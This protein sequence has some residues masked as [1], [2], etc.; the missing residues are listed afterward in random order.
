MT[1]TLYLIDGSGF[2]F[3]AYHA[4]PPLT[5]KDGTPVGAVYGFLNMILKLIEG[6]CADYLAVIFDAGRF[7]FRNEIYDKY[8][9]NRTET[10]E[11]LI[12]QFPLVREATAAMNL[13]AIELAGFEADDLIASYTRA[14]REKGI[15]VVIVSSD[16]DLM[17]LIGDGV[18]MYDAM[19]GRNIG[20]EQVKEKFG[21]TPDKVLDVLSLIG[22]SSDNVPGVPGIGPKTA[23]ELIEQFGDLD[24]VLARAGEIKQNKR[25]ES[26]IEFAA[27]ARMS[28]EL[29]RLKDDVPLPMAFEEITLRKPDNQKLFDFA[30]AMEFKS[31][32]AKLGGMFGLEARVGEVNTPSLPNSQQSGE[33]GQQTFTSP[34]VGEVARSTGEGVK[35]SNITTHHT[36]ITDEATLAKHLREAAASGIIAFD[37]ETTSLNAMQAEIVGFSFCMQAGTAFYVPLGHVK[38]G[39][40]APAGDLFAVAP[41]NNLVEGQIPL[42]IALRHLKQVLEDASILKIGQNIKYD[43]LVL[44]KY[45]IDVVSID[46]TMVMSYCM[47]AGKTTHGMDAMAERYLGHKCISYDE[48]TGTGKSRISFAEVALDKACAYA[49]EDAD[50]TLRLWQVIKSRLI[51]EKKVTLYETIERPLIPVLV[52]MEERGIKLDMPKLKELSHDFESRMRVLEKTIYD[53]AGG[54]FN[55]GSPKQLG[56]ILF[57]KLAIPGGKK[58]AKTGSYPTG[59]DIL[60]ELVA[61]GFEIA[62]QVLEWRQLSK[63]KST[64]TDALAEQMN[65][66]TGRVHTSFAMAIT[67]TG[68]LS[69]S[70]PNLQ[71]IPIR[72]EEGRKIRHAFISER[73]FKLISADYSQIE[74]RLLAHVA[75]MD[76]LKQA[77]KEGKDIHALTASQMFGVP[78]DQMTSE[79]RRRAKSINFGIIYGISAHGLAAN[80]G[81]SRAEAADYIGKYFQQY[82]GIQ[83]YMERTK[84]FAHKHGY[85]E[86][87]FGR[88]CH[89]PNINDKNSGMRQ[90]SERAAINAPLQGSAADIIK[91]AMI[92][93]EQALAGSDARMLLQVHDELVLEAPEASANM[94]AEKVKHIMQSVAHLSVP[95][96]VETG[97]GD[98]WGSIH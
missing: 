22:D 9:A 41:Q 32:V 54:E 77:F 2:I 76:S 8:K 56:E 19:K 78:L 11:D 48:V 87:I 90:F 20:L 45:G 93:V 64:Y 28:R 74:L 52:A 63:L 85:V 51:A 75:D 26:L 36:L 61:D 35:Q 42:D 13:P 59:A 37:T 46:D 97:V 67:S 25:R 50:I 95:L 73:G 38:Q 3:R 18:S 84:E 29:V 68:R 5:R 47:D 80:L 21:V 44:K 30:Q 43:M 16:K 23:A 24:S 49:A 98:D 7:T 53:L 55:V 17:Q 89:V 10:P 58:S 39:N 27:Q 31:L 40:A 71:N 92:K 60:E 34:F 83:A 88:I 91:M 86:T 65:S 15:E 94:V 72:T 66:K 4:L 69:S 57:E 82:P 79:L 12:P 81:I 70:D 62:K 33:R 96:L 6:S 14:A 1:K